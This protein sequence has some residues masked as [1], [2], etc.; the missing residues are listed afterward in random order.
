MVPIVDPFAGLIVEPFWVAFFI[1]HVDWLGKAIVSP[2]WRVCVHAAIRNISSGE[3]ALSP[4]RLVMAL[5]D[6]HTK[7]CALACSWIETK[8]SVILSPLKTNR[9][10]RPCV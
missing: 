9:G 8:Y 1:R 6:S 4:I 5:F 3:M 10:K 2:A 7:S